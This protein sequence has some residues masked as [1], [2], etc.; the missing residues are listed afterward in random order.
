MTITKHLFNTKLDFSKM[1]RANKDDEF[2]VFTISVPKTYPCIGIMRSETTC[3]EDPFNGEF[4]VMEDYVYPFDF[5][6]DSGELF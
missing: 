5:K 3:L 1:R 4:H 6:N 2:N